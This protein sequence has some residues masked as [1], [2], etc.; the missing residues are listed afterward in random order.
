MASPGS[1]SVCAGS[2]KRMLKCVGR[3]LVL[4]QSHPQRVRPAHTAIASRSTWSRKLAGRLLGVSTS[5]SMP[6]NCF[7][8]NRI[9]P[10]SISVVCAVGSTKRSRSLSAVSSPCSA[11]P[12]TR[13]LLTRWRSAISRICERWRERASEGRM[14]LEFS[15]AAC[16]LARSAASLGEV[17]CGLGTPIILPR[18]GLGTAHRLI[19]QLI[20]VF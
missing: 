16:L 9:A 11:E 6:S 3:L 14:V 8:S 17:E 19:L 15:Y 12:N 7:S 10:M 18:T 2:C 1:C 5:T 4:W 20:P 13:T